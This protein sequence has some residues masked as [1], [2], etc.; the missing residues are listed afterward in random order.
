[1]IKCCDWNLAWIKELNRLP[2]HIHSV[3]N[4]RGGGVL[5]VEEREQCIESFISVIW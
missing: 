1:M 4:H 3:L 5:L 2:Q